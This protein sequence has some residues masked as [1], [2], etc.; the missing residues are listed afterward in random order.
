VP[1]VLFLL[2]PRESRLAKLDWR[3]QFRNPGAA[4]ITLQMNR[5]EALIISAGHASGCVVA[6]KLGGW[7]AGS[8]SRRPVNGF[9]LR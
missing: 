3:S 7:S 8:G 4:E 2:I 6:M 5:G 9:S 1:C